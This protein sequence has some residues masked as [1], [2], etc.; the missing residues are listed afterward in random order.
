MVDPLHSSAQPERQILRRT[1]LKSLASLGV[2]TV[3]FQRA[4]AVTAA[5]AGKVTPEM[6]RDAEWITGLTLT[7]EERAS[8]AANVE[9]SLQARKLIR[10]YPVGYATPPALHFHPAPQ[11][12]A[13]VYQRVGRVELREAAEPRRPD[14][15]EDIAFLP[16]T[17]LAALIRARRLTSLELTKI[18]LERLKHYDPLLKC[19]ITLTEELALK[20]AANADR[21]IAAGR[22]RGPLH[23]IPWGA[24]DLIA[25]PG[26]KTTWGAGPFQEQ[27]LDEKATVAQRLDDAG[28]VLLAKLSLGALAWG[29]EWFGGMTRNPWNTREGSS[30]SSAGSACA[31][32]AGLVGFTLGSETLGSIVS[33]STRC[34]ASGHRPTFGRVSRYGCMALAWSMD[35]IGPICRSVEDCALVF[36]A[37]HGYDGLDPTAVDFPFAW[38]SARDLRTLRVGYFDN[39]MPV[40]QRSELAVLRDLGVTLVRV[41]LPDAIPAWALTLIL[42]AESAAVFDP[43]VRS[44]NLAGTGRWPDELREGQFVSAVEY[45]QAQRMRTLLMREMEALFETVDCTIAG[46]DLTITNLTGHPS[47]V[48]PSAFEMRDGREVPVALTFTGKLYGDETLLALAHAFQT[49]TGLHLRR[50][51]L[52]EETP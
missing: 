33:P 27:S 41:A 5:D 21:E 35:K 40:D 46:D 1:I 14:S 20:Q 19:V 39:G 3:V 29:D 8:T 42:S 17:E 43:L 50:P 47:V 45:L 26:Y 6:I 32:A 10:E 11:Q 9:R 36:G 16:V 18:Y 31:A 28:A 52:A 13:S 34:G 30:G 4:L 15:K 38:P 23:G 44:N 7:D 37:I 24:K 25:Y 12:P 22:Y 51:R 49:A 2:G 48:L